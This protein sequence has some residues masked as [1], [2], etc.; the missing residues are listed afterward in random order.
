MPSAFHILR[1]ADARRRSM[2]W[3]TPRQ[4]SWDSLGRRQWRVRHCVSRASSTRA[5]RWRRR[6]RRTRP[7]QPRVAPSRRLGRLGGL[8]SCAQWP[9][10]SAPQPGSASGTS[11]GAGARRWQSGT[12]AVLAV[13]LECMEESRWPSGP[14]ILICSGLR[15][16]AGNLARAAVLDSARA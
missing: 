10:R 3:A 13:G 11:V 4:V 15:A 8:R 14:E 1:H 7:I 16:A 2:R 5:W 6:C 9:A 12:I